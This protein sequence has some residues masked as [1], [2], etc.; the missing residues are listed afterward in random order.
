M[1]FRSNR[2]AAL[3]MALAI[4][5]ILVR[6]AGAATTASTVDLSPPAQ[7]ALEVLIQLAP[8]VALVIGSMITWALGRIGLK[9]DAQQG[10]FMRQRLE[11]LLNSGVNLAKSRLQTRFDGLLTVDVHNEL[12][13]TVSNYVLTHG[14][15]V[16]KY[17]RL[18]DKDSVLR[19]KAE[20]WLAAQGLVPNA[21]GV[22]RVGNAVPVP[23][24]A[25]PVQPRVDLT[26]P[27]NIGSSLV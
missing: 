11:A 16:T 5:L 6:A 4:L 3:L 25:V 14:S 23:A 17:Y 12:L 19:E 1:L 15:A 22:V 10:E 8:I 20:A 24:G 9:Q 27:T 21:A 7:F 18:N 2:S 13:A 26:A